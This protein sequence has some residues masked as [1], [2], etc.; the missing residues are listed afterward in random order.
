MDGHIEKT[1]CSVYTMNEIQKFLKIDKF[2][3][4]EI[5]VNL[6]MMS[7]LLFYRVVND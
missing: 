4:I 2:Q 7:D 1:R 5:P 6:F 3:I